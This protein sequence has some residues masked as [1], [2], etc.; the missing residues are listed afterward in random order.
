MPALAKSGR[1]TPLTVVSELL[2]LRDFP[3]V[4]P[5]EHSNVILVAKRIVQRVA[6]QE[7]LE[8]GLGELQ[9]L[10]DAVALGHRARAHIAH[11]ALDRNH[12]HRL[13]QRLALVQ[14]PH[15]V[16]RDAGR[17]EPA[18]H[19]GVDLVVR[20]ALLRKLRELDAVERRHVVPVMHDEIAG[21]VRGKDRLRLPLVELLPRFHSCLPF[22]S[23]ASRIPSPGWRCRS[24]RA[25]SPMPRPARG[26]R[27][28]A[29][30]SAAKGGRR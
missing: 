12:L 26:S 2:H 4:R 21:I 24:M 5:S 30:C 23:R 28:P 13:H 27:A 1:R 16:R 19:V 10:L 7:K 18:H 20:F 29:C 8:D 11:D 17:G 3:G 22:T 6:L 25:D 9:A 15:E 14:E